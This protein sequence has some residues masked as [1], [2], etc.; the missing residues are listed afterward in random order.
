MIESL[1]FRKRFLKLYMMVIEME[2][3]FSGLL[4]LSNDSKFGDQG[5]L[6]RVDKIK[7]PQLLCSWGYFFESIQEAGNRCT[8][9]F[10][11]LDACGFWSF[12]EPFIEI[13]INSLADTPSFDR[14]FHSF[15]TFSL[16]VPRTYSRIHVTTQMCRK[17]WKAV[18]LARHLL[19]SKLL[20]CGTI[21]YH[22]YCPT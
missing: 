16:R 5:R 21:M 7:W 8:N 14:Q 10:W 13:L 12:L 18:F 1:N 11:A 6:D 4:I 9:D 17:F 2:P 3:T 22:N 20:L 15:Q 19:E